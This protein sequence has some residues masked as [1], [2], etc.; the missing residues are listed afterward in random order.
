MRTTSSRRFVGALAPP[1]KLPIELATFV[2]GAGK[3]PAASRAAAFG[4]IMQGGITL[5]GNCM[6]D[7]MVNGLGLL[8]PGQ[9]A[10]RT[11]PAT[12]AFD[13]LHAPIVVPG[14]QKVGTNIGFGLDAVRRPARLPP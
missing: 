6:P 4:L 8:P 14:P 13:P 11:L 2:V 1:T 10:N 9:L 12:C 3:M 5:P 7:W